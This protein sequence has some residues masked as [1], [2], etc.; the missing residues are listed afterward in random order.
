LLLDQ[1]HCLRIIVPKQAHDGVTLRKHGGDLVLRKSV[2]RK[3][4]GRS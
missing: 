1:S 4:A 2:E 3:L